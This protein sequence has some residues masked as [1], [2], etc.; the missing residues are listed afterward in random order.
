MADGESNYKLGPGRQQLHTRFK[1]GQSGN[2]RGRSLKNLATLPADALNEMVYVTIDGRRR[3]I[4]E[5]EVIVTEMVNK[6]TSA[7]L[8]A[9]KMLI[10]M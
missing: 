1:K 4:T 5:R 3:K 8:R 10:D 6:S 2:P 7:D 9:T